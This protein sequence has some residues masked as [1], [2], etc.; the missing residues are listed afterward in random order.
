VFRKSIFINKLGFILETSLFLYHVQK[1]R[2]VIFPYVTIP[3]ITFPNITIP[4][5]RNNPERN[6]LGEGERD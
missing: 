5:I 6:K 3:N 2:Y 4:N 1:R